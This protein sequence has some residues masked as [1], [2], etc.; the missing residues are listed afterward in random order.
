MLFFTARQGNL[1]SSGFPWKQRTW[2][3]ITFANAIPSGLTSAN[4]VQVFHTFWYKRSGGSEG[5]SYTRCLLFKAE[6]KRRKTNFFPI[7]HRKRFSVET[8]FQRTFHT[9]QHVYFLQPNT[10]EETLNVNRINFIS[11]EDKNKIWRTRRI[12]WCLQWS[13]QSVYILHP[14][15]VNLLFKR[16]PT[17]GL[18]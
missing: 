10:K 6:Y 9:A 4:F 14:G 8:T 18:W 15:L 13:K 16:S 11:S 12:I 2:T 17:A 1:N 3:P 5:F 7:F